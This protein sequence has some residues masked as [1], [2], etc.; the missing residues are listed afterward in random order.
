MK[1][2][3]LRS[4]L[5]PRA[6]FYAAWIGD[7][8]FGDAV[9]RKRRVASQTKHSM[10]TEI[11]DGPDQGFQPQLSWAGVSAVR[12]LDVITLLNDRG[13]AFLTIKNIQEAPQP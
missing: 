8:R 13:D 9:M 6:T 3:K 12:D 7:D 1:L 2:K 5:Q 11:L 10:V 4:K